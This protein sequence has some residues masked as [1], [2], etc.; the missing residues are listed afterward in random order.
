MNVRLNNLN[1][2]IIL[3]IVIILNNSNYCQSEIEKPNILWIT[4][5]DNSPFLGC[6]GDEF[7]TTPN[8]D[9]F[10][11]QGVLFENAYATAPV[12]APAR[13]SIITGM[14]PPSLGTQHMRSNNPI[15]KMIKFFPQ[16]LREAGY[17]CTNNR[18]KDY[19]TIEPKDVWDE[20]SRKATY[21]NRAEH[22][23]FFAVFNITVSHESSLHKTD[24]LL[25]HNSDSV[26]IPAYHPETKDIRKD[27]AQYYDKVEDMDTQVG[28][29]LEQLDNDGL[30][31]NTIVFYYSDHGGILCRSKRFC[32][33]SGL[34]V[35]M[36]IRFPKKYKSLEISKPGTKTDQIISFVDFAP[37]ILSLA[38][39]SIPNYMQ[40]KSFLG[41]QQ[42]EPRNYAY[43]F[44]G[45]MDERYDFS[46]TVRDKRYRYIKNYMPHRIYGQHIEYLW[47]SPATKSWEQAYKEGK[48]N[49]VQ[50][51][52]WNTKPVE[53]LYDLINDPSEVNNLAYHPD[54]RK[55]CKELRKA[56]SNWQKDIHDSGFIPESQMIEIANNQK[57]Y[58][59]VRSD[60]YKL[61][62]I[63]EV[64]N[65][66]IVGETSNIPYLLKQLKNNDP[67]IR[68]WAATGFLIMGNEANSA[69]A[70]LEECLIDSSVFVRIAAAEA[71]INLG[72]IAKAIPVLKEALHSE[73]EKTVLN[74]ANVFNYIGD[75]VDNIYDEL[76]F[77]LNH[78]SSYVQR[79]ARHISSKLSSKVKKQN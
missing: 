77:L 41:N 46:R 60:K 12:C 5:E 52:F 58:D 57:I 76:D 53:E 66:A 38:G 20:S 59:F 43:S 22:Q 9:K 39:I 49:S 3:F 33:D 28:K 48:C 30:S 35:P 74:A 32:Y 64:A 2:I 24:S 73:N 69:S 17:Y 15:P 19:N 34:R 25:R 18:K 14:Y 45:R 26:K 29:I 6:Y 55:K 78:K 63:M 23:P 56:C 10:A 62:Q 37:T 70:D 68:Y 50:S 36:I 16:Y 47:K 71:L 72:S 13:N 54:Y 79:V 11:E 27:W 21:S 31:E 7:A 65:I 4:S 40:G 1:K 44:R 67:I 8:L 61:E 42:A 51:I 75:E